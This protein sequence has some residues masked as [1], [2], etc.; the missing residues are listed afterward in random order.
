M[1]APQFGA[2]EGL[3]VPGVGGLPGQL[4]SVASGP[5]V[6]PLG[7]HILP[8]FLSQVGS[9]ELPARL[10]SHGLPAPSPHW[11]RAVH[12]NVAPSQEPPQVLPL[13]S[14][15]PGR[16]AVLWTGPRKELPSDA[17]SPRV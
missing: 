5:N 1:T 8:S 4:Q 12:P 11:T 3:R 6:P 15:S 2:P 10:P 13:S 16:G 9:W 17:Q 7:L 14:R